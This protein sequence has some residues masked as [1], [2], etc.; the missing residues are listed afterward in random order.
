MIKDHR[1]RLR[2]YQNTFTGQE[3][4]QWLIKRKEAGDVDEAIILGQAL[5]DNGLMHHGELGWG[6]CEKKVCVCVREREKMRKRGR[7]R[8]VS[9][10]EWEGG[11]ETGRKRL[12][13][14]REGKGEGETKRER[15][16]ERKRERENNYYNIN[17]FE[18]NKFPSE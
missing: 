13:K 9:E 2:T 16:R 5:V 10:R 7:K 6:V 12:G 14:G 1:V 3:M 18:F 8:F 11:R 4:V 17:L 15:E